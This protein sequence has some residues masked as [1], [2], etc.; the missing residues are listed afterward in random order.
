VSKPAGRERILIG[1][2]RIANEWP[3]EERGENTLNEKGGNLIGINLTNRHQWQYPNK[4]EN[5]HR[6]REREEG[7][8]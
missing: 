4:R 8:E 3:L 1:R 7:R 5:T 2:E 6:K